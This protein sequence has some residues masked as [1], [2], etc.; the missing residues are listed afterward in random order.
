MPVAR[1]EPLYPLFVRPTHWLGSELALVKR[2][3][4][5]NNPEQLFLLLIYP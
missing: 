4:R 5:L 3:S 2:H 1:R